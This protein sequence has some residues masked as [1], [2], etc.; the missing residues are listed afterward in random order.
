VPLTAIPDLQGNTHPWYMS[1]TA[2]ID[3]SGNINTTTHLESHIALSGFTG[4]MVAAFL[5]SNGQSE[6]TTPVLQYGVDGYN[7]P[8]WL[9]GTPSPRDVSASFKVDPAFY[10]EVSSINIDLFYAPHNRFGTD[11]NQVLPRVKDVV[12]WIG[13]LF[14]SSSS[15]NS[16]VVSSTGQAL[17]AVGPPSGGGSPSG[18]G[19]PGGG[20]HPIGNGPPPR[21]GERP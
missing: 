7:V 16:S 14:G 9:G 5:N 3:D 6:F 4:G 1:G 13:S 20:G 17:T 11:I 8:S 21:G 10:G 2:S 19:H 15:S 12:Q 18:G